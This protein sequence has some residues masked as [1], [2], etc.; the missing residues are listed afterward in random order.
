[1]TARPKRGGLKRALAILLSAPAVA[2][3][4]SGGGLTTAALSLPSLG[5]ENQRPAVVGSAAA[6]YTRLGRGALTCWFGANG[7]LRGAYI[8]NAD[9]EPP[10][11]GGRA[12]IL[13]H[14]KEMAAE[15][16]RG[17]KA[18]R[19]T[20]EPAGD[21]ASLAVENLKV[22]EPLAAK[23]KADVD[24]WAAGG[25]GCGEGGVTSAWS[26]QA[27]ADP[28]TASEKAKPVQKTRTGKR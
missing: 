5:P 25:V 28:A 18:F 13:I 15:S 26:P 7:P 21:Q 12:E 14:V 19:I 6:L 11:R 9:A 1:M 22:P 20:I 17:V 27:P 16:P 8:Y 2:G 10:S 23:L 4:S 24:R 3:C